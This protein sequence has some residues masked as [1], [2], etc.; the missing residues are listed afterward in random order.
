[1]IG[2]KDLPLSSF[3]PPITEELPARSSLSYWPNGAFRMEIVFCQQ[4]LGRV[5]NED[6][7]AEANSNDVRGRH[8]VDKVEVAVHLTPD[9]VPVDLLEGADDRAC[10]LRLVGAPLGARV[11]FG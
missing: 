2:E 6:S 1:M 4:Y 3:G 8:D 10:I 7:Q 9:H 11:G 5:F